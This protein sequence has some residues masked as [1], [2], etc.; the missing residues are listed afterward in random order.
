MHQ[1]RYI[2]PQFGFA[3]IVLVAVWMIGLGSL[4]PF[5]IAELFFGLDSLPRYAAIGCCYGMVGWLCWV[6]TLVPSRITRLLLR[7]ATAII[8]SYVV[9][10]RFYEPI[11]LDAA[12]IIRYAIN[13][14]GMMVSQSILF[15][16]LA[17]PPWQMAGTPLDHP[18]QR[19]SIGDLITLTTCVA[20]ILT[21]G[22]HY[23]PP[24]ERSLYW[25]W[26]IGI[27]AIFPLTSA[28]GCIAVLHTAT[29]RRVFWATLAIALIAGG[30][31]VLG[32]QESKWVIRDENFVKFAGQ[33]AAIGIGNLFV[34]A[35]FSFA[36]RMEAKWTGANPTVGES[37]TGDSNL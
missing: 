13:F 4:P 20:A 10:V 21:L 19:L 22:S 1:S 18:R 3:S 7:T 9:Q 11:H 37:E 26:L 15:R 14:G 2:L 27:W 17:I 35:A 33:Y 31:L 29:M 12:H 32:A 16:L 5:A 25:P 8:W 6:L 30:S 24:V 34:M 36:G 23:R 28:G